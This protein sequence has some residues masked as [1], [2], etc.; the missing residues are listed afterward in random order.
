V[1]ALRAVYRIWSSLIAAAVLVQ[2]G[3][4]GYGAF[5]SSSHEQH[6][7]S[8]LTHKQ[9][10]H[11]WNFHSA[12]GWITVYGI[13][14]ALLLA[15]IARVGRPRIWWQLGLAVAGVLQIVFALVGEKHPAVGVLHPLNALVIAAVAGQ[16]AGREWARVRAAS[17]A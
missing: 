8:V 10:D 5:Y 15:L 9:F 17:P 14:I 13:L 1:E 4:A 2:I 6:T 12:L 7:T 11:G 16:I 3:A